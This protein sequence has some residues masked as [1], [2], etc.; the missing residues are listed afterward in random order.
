MCVVSG[1]VV[2]EMAVF[3]EKINHTK[4]IS[5]QTENITFFKLTCSTKLLQ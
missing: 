1:D 3:N 5:G 2:Y 4:S